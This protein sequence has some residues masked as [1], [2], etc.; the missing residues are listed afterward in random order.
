MTFGI[1]TFPGA[2]GDKELKYILE[3]VYDADVQMLWHNHTGAFNVSAVILPAG[4]PCEDHEHGYTSGEKYPVLQQLHE[5]AGKG[6]F[7]LGLGNGFRTLCQEG[8]LPGTLRPN[9]SGRYICKNVYIKPD[10]DYSA[11]THQFQND[12]AYRIPIATYAGKYEA[13]EQVLRQM[14]QEDQIV[15]RYCDPYGKIS[16]RVN[17]TGSADNIAGVCNTGKN[18]FGMIPLP[19]RAV[20]YADEYGDGKTLFESLISFL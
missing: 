4:F 8:L 11:V 20:I 3:E 13:G 6:G 1:L 5:F 10:N 16:E 17:D 9:Q 7:V 14:R 2:H 12:R 19:E 18:V 15:F